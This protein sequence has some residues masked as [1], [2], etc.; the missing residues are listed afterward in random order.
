MDMSAFMV[1]MVII[2]I[3]K[4]CSFSH[5]VSRIKKK[6]GIQRRGR[7]NYNNAHF[8]NNRNYN[9]NQAFMDEM[10]RQQNQFF[11]DECLK[12]VT[13]WEMGGYDMNNGN[14]FNNFGNGMF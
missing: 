7:Y 14:S 5:K 6:K 3:L 11:M 1:F 10:N 2:A 4:I 8:M 9:W 13:P 12:S